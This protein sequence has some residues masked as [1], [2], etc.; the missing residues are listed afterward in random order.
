M[1]LLFMTNQVLSGGIKDCL[2]L[3]ILRHLMSS[4]MIKIVYNTV[5]VVYPYS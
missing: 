1:I 2:L 3:K 4:I 5:S